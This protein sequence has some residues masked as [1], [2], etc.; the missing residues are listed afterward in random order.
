MLEDMEKQAYK[1]KYAAMG[2][3][4]LEDIFLHLTGTD[5]RD[6]EG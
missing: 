1:D 3:A 6:M 5:L 2:L 4:T